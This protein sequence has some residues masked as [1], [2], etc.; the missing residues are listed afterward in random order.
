M[1]KFFNK[2]IENRFIDKLLVNFFIFLLFFM[3]IIVLFYLLLNYPY[4]EFLTCD[5]KECSLEQHFLFSNSK[6][7]N[8][9]K[10]TN[11]RVYS[12]GGNRFRSYSL[13]ISEYDKLFNSTYY[14]PY[15]A[16]K[17]KDLIKSNTEKIKITKYNQE[18]ITL[19]LFNISL[20]ILL[21]YG[22]INY[23]KKHSK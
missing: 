19:L 9:N 16:F 21:I 15:F 2:K 20:V 22:R 7:S 1:T 18:I 5:S 3:P 13:M 10:P 11:I 14:I 23:I 8:I 4:K 17:D 12:S 6:I